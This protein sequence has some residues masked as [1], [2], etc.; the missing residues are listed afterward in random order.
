MIPL[1]KMNSQDP[2]RKVWGIASTANVPDLANLK[3]V[4]LRNNLSHVQQKL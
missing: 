4:T 1:H 2:K 3:P